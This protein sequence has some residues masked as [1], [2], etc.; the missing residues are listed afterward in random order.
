MT[1]TLLSSC[2]KVFLCRICDV[3]LGSMRTV[4]VVRGKTIIASLIGFFEVFIWFIIVKDAL[5]T[6]GPVIPIAVSYALGYACGTYIGGTLAKL[7]TAGHVTMHVVTSDVN[8]ELCDNLRQ[9]GFGITVLNVN[10]SPYG[11]EKNL[12][13][14]DLSGK[15]LQEFEKIVKDADPGAFILV[16]ETKQHIGGYARPGK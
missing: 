15:R 1:L 7:L 11:D 10:D 3:T 5:N 4:L 2:L 8:N 12:I 14:A 13:L 9:S 16:Q 6:Q